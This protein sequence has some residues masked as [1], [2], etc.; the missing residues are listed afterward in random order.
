MLPT[1]HRYWSRNAARREDLR[2]TEDSP[3]AQVASRIA[4]C[5]S[6]W[7]HYDKERQAMIRAQLERIQ[8]AEGLSDNCLEI[9]YKSLHG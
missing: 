5:F 8:H 4:S 2:L 9:V 6:S 7:R 1:G 3:V